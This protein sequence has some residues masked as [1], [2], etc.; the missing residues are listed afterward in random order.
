VGESKKANERGSA[1]K[2]FL[3][4]EPNFPLKTPDTLTGFFRSHARIAR[5]VE[6]RFQ[7]ARGDAW[8]FRRARGNRLEACSTKNWQEKAFTPAR[9]KTMLLP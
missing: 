6:H 1:S 8:L 5:K 4:N 2:A 7:P 3:P 9:I